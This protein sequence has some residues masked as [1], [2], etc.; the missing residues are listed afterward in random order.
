NFPFFFDFRRWR[1]HTGRGPLLA[2]FL[3]D[4]GRAFRSPLNEENPAVA[5]RGDQRQR[6]EALSILEWVDRIATE[7][8]AAWKGVKPPRIEDFGG[9]GSGARRAALVEELLRIDRAYR[10]QLGENQVCPASTPPAVP[11][12][13]GMYATAPRFD[14]G[15]LARAAPE[16]QQYPN[17]SGPRTGKQT[18]SGP[19]EYADLK[20][21]DLGKALLRAEIAVPGYEILG[22]LGRGGMGV[23]YKARH[24]QLKRLAALKVILG[25]AHASAEQLAR[26]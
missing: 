18:L 3:D 4:I 5:D 14:A 22:E 6:A 13:T 12:P 20:G 17:A 10:E 21:A 24:V 19:K 11:E 23:V 7:Y 16:P 1:D 26:F 2:G 9:E 15:Q 8:E 25:G